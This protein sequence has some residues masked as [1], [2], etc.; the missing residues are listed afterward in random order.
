MY[1]LDLAELK[2]LF[3]LQVNSI[4]S[5]E[6]AAAFLNVSRQRVGQLITPSS[7]DLPS[8]VQIFKL[9]QVAGVSH[10]LT[11][12]GAKAT[13]QGRLDAMEAGLAVTTAG[14]DFCSALHSAFADGLID[15]REHSDLVSRARKTVEAGQ[16]Q[17]DAARSLR[18]AGADQ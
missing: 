16:R 11:P 10:V 7:P 3:C 8:L 13:M 6:A 18:T 5:H 17:F 12:L 9:Q 4:G 14:S 1:D 2:A 15:E